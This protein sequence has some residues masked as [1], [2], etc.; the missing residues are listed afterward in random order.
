[1]EPV[2]PKMQILKGK[3][4]RPPATLIYGVDGIG[5]STWAAKAPR[6]IFIQTEDRIAHIDVDKFELAKDFEAVLLQ[7]KFLIEEKHD[8]QTLV[9]DSLDWTEKLIFA[10][11]CRENGEKA[12]NSNAKGS[13]LSYGRGYQLA[14]E[15]WGMLRMGLDILRSRRDM[16]IVLI[17]HSKI[18]KFED[19]LRENYDRYEIDLQE[20]ASSM[21]QQWCDCVFFANFETIVRKDNS[22]S[23]KGVGTGRRLIYTEERPAFDA[24]N[25]Y[26]LPPEIELKHSTFA[27]GYKKYFKQNEKTGE[28][29]NG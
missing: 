21:W 15:K 13:A 26:D 27:E 1:M 29:K 3:Q 9:I 23:L 17:A 19:P 28:I 22:D 11:V 4:N 2:K 18:R 6:P 14:L 8:Y 16:G 20:K 25:S 7:V 10:E 5:K 12:I 24:K